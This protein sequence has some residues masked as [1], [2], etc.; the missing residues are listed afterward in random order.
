MDIRSSHYLTD[1][2]FVVFG[3]DF[4]YMNAFWNYQQMDAM[5]DYMNEH[6]SDRYV[7][8][9]STPS[10]YV[11]ALDKYDVEW[12]TKYDDLIAYS[13]SPHSYWSGFYS[14]RPN[15]KAYIRRASSQMEAA[16]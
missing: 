16:N 2:V 10:T 6:H 14:S 4:R 9:Y 13:D 12:P 11:D 5:I 3:G 1:D 7:F 15:N 8:K